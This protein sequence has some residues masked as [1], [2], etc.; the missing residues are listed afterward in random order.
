MLPKLNMMWRNLQGL[1]QMQGDPYI[2]V[3]R[4]G[5]GVTL[6]L[7]IQTLRRR[8]VRVG[9]GGG[10]SMAFVKAAPGAVTTVDC[11]LSTVDNTGTE[12]EVNCSVIGGSG[13]EKLNAAVPR[14]VDG[15]LIFVQQFGS[16]WYCTQAFIATDDCECVQSDAVLNSLTI[17]E[18]EKI[19]LDGEGGD[20][21]IRYNSIDGDVEHTVDGDKVTTW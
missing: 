8:L 9:G 10:A 19:T 3:R 4:A 12:I 6:N 20:T 5:T 11:W 14:L 2:N 16:D 1:T 13:S 18:D 7:N 17:N 21:F 15:S